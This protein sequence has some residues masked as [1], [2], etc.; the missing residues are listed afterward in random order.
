MKNEKEF[1]KPQAEIIMFLNEDVILTSIIDEYDEND[2]ISQ[3]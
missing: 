3:G 2:P 1:K